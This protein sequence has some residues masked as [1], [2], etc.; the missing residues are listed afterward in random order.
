MDDRYYY[1]KD[2]TSNYGKDSLQASRSKVNTT[3][4]LDNISDNDH[5]L[6]MI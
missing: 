1:A 5:Q 2:T 3:G 6:P 4:I